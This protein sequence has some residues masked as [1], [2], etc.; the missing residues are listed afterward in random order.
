MAIAT[1][2]VMSVIPKGIIFPWASKETK[3]PKGWALC[4]GKDGRPNLDGIFLRGTA[5]PAAVGGT[6][7]SASQNHGHTVG[8]SGAPSGAGFQGDGDDCQLGSASDVT[9]NT[10]PPF[11]T[12]QYI[13][14]L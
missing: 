13:I 2:D 8:K 9:I 1:D 3:P 12:V 5:S 6:G 14:K 10:I 7:G 4:D 11:Y